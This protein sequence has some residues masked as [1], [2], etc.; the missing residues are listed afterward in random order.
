MNLIAT[1]GLDQTGFEGGLKRADAGLKR[2]AGAFGIAFGAGSIA[3]ATR[4]A[5]QFAEQIDRSAQK[6]GLTTAEFQRLNFA[7]T[8]NKGSTD[9]MER[10]LVE[11]GKR[12]A[13]TPQYFEKWGVALNN[14]D[15][16]AKTINEL[17]L[18]IS[19]RIA[20]AATQQE[21][22]GIASE[23]VGRAGTELVPIFQLGAEAIEEMG[24]SANIMAE[25]SVAAIAR[26]NDAIDAIKIGALV[27]IANVIGAILN[28]S[29]ASLKLAFMEA[30]VPLQAIGNFFL[31]L[32]IAIAGSIASG[33]GLILAA[34][35]RPLLNGVDEFAIYLRNRIADSLENVRG[36]GGVAERL[37]TER[38]A[39]LR[40]DIVADN[41]ELAAVKVGDFWDGAL[42]GLDSSIEQTKADRAAMR[43]PTK[44]ATPPE[45]TPQPVRQR[46]TITM[47]DEVVT[48]GTAA[49][50]PSILSTTETGKADMRTTEQK[51]EQ[52]I[53]ETTA[54]NAILRGKFAAE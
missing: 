35:V 47:G 20:G 27:S 49:A 36:F 42:Q 12:A 18:E 3:L 17:F 6:T 53:D 21:R 32:P 33:T 28:P 8:Q 38:P 15:G 43:D 4:S 5:V 19:D 45:A 23:L 29:G 48:L 41:L 30:L 10:A 24:K 50:R 11:I 34:I 52:L 22:L 16:S 44:E 51:L 2:F 31:R 39:Q 13:A 46:G 54:Q 40:G 7:V 9:A 14:A 37:R 25:D 1:L 26:I